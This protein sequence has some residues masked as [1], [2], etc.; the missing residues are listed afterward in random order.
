M[1]LERAVVE[2]LFNDIDPQYVINF[3]SNKYKKKN[4][5]LVDFKVF[6]RSSIERLKNYSQDEIEKIYTGIKG[7]I[8]Y[9]NPA[10]FFKYLGEFAS[11]LLVYNEYEPKINY[12]YLMRWNEISHLLGQDILTMPFLA[13]HDYL[14][15]EWTE[16]FA[17]KAVISTNNRQLFNI[18]D[19]GMAENHF[20]LKGSSHIFCLNWLSLMNHPN[21][22]NDEFK[23]FSIKLK[24]YQRYKN[25]YEY[26]MY[27]LIKLAA[28]LRIYF[29]I[30]INNYEI[31]KK[32][33]N[34]RKIENPINLKAL[35]TDIVN[36]T[37][38]SE[39]HLKY[40]ATIKGV[41]NFKSSSDLDYALLGNVASSNGKN[42]YFVGERRIMYLA[43]RMMFSNNFS[44]LESIC[45]YLYILIKNSFRRELIQVNKLYGFRN[46]S[47]YEQRKEIFIEKFS[48]YNDALIKKAIEDTFTNQ[49]IISLEA[50]IVPKNS[51]KENI[52]YINKLD[53]LTNE[54]KDKLFYVFHFVKKKE[55]PLDNIYKCRNYKVRKEIEYQSKC[56]AKALENNYS[57]RNRIKGI[58]ACSNEYFCRPEVFGQV[59]RFLSNLHLNSI[60][61]EKQVPIEIYK[62][63][64][65]GED[66]LDIADGLRAIDE[67]IIFCDL[68]SG[69]RLGH[70]TVLGIDVD[71]FYKDKHRIFMTKLEFVDN[72]I[73]LIK[74]AEI[75]NINVDKYPCSKE[76]LA[77]AYL[78][79]DEIYYDLSDQYD[80]NDYY[81]AWLLRGDNP[82]CYSKDGYVIDKTNII[83]YDF[84]AKNYN[85]ND[86]KRTEKAIKLYYAYHYNEKIKIKGQE[87]YDFEIISDYVK[88]IKEVQKLMRFEIARKGIFIEC[89]PTS[90]YLIANLKRYEKH[91]II[92]FYNDE[93]YNGLDTEC[94][95]LN[96]SINTDDQG[97][98][99]TSLENEYALM[100]YSLENFQDKDGYV[101]TPN[102]VYKWIDSVRKMG[103]EQKFK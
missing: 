95:Q 64:H 94:A 17:Y 38:L 93:L 16:F 25:I 78:I 24:P 47:D 35:L 68:N 52:D 1:K 88:L 40:L 32:S 67:A 4:T 2:I 73:W 70:A 37:S 72:V 3:L 85:V 28:I 63:Y 103:I 71:E 81:H 99:D 5:P 8:D 31:D 56:I 41:L 74:K 26:K 33:K 97:V 96:V 86:S 34:L 60:G 23:K 57:F 39:N 6:Y 102:K 22:R 49:K 53:Q 11:T 18:L 83:K 13:Y 77:K 10:T 62:T 90:N 43:S 66:F 58:D 61:I 82:N 59:F 50:R 29:F 92:N 46:F 100:A 69:S 80:K 21:G 36:K 87:V 84:F 55:N 9:N 7:K 19:Q 76:L 89:N 30:K 91:P 48:K 75:L 44:R 51:A 14:Y 54:Y 15:G 98:F 45:F 20:H 65:V 101:F 27:D 79:M 12:Q 42:E